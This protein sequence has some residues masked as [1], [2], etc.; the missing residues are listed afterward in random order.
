MRGV[1]IEWL[2]L[3]SKLRMSTSNRQI[4]TA[5]SPHEHSVAVPLQR[6]EM[7]HYFQIMTPVI[8]IEKL[9][10]TIFIITIIL[11]CFYICFYDH[12]KVSDI[13]RIAYG[14]YNFALV[15]K[16]K[17][18]VKFLSEIVSPS[19]KTYFTHIKKSC[20]YNLTN[21]ARQSHKNEISFHILL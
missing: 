17:S 2:L 14:S 9:T 21:L 3:K 5:L 6:G 4:K 10:S 8:S 16:F 1:E 20:P 15:F 19:P 18:N 11:Q 13:K 7:T 12:N